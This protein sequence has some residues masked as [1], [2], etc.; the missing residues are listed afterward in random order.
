MNALVT[1]KKVIGPALVLA[2]LTGCSGGSGEDVQQNP[3]PPADGGE[4]GIVYNGPSPSTDDVQNFRLNLWDNIAR[5]DRCG[6][7]HVVGGQQPTFARADDINLAYSDANPLVD[8]AAPELSR[9]VTKVAE[10]HNCWR[11]EASVCATTMAGYIRDWATASGTESNQI[12][13][14]APVE[15]E[16]GTSKS[17]PSDGGNFATTVYPL[18]S[19][20]CANCH[21]EESATQQQPFI[22]SS[23][24]DV[25]YQAARNKIDL[26]DPGNSRLVLRLRSEFHNCWDNCTAN[27]QAMEDAIQAFSD[28][29]PLTEVDP[30]LRVSRALGLPD[31]IVAS[32]GGRVES[33]AIALYEFKTGSGSTAF[34]TSGVDPALDLNITGNVEWVGSWGIRINDGKAQGPTSASSKLHQL[35]T[36]TGEFSIEA[37]VVPDNVSQDGPARIVTYSGGSDVRNFTLGQTLYDY[38]FLARSSESDANGMPMLSTPSN[39]E[40]LQATLQHVVVN[41]DPIDGRSIYVNGELIAENTD[42]PGNLNDWDETFA[43]AVGNEADNQQ[44]WM[45]TM[46][47]LA[48]H[49]RVLSADEITTNFDAGVGEK[50]F[51]MFGV[52][53]YIDMP[54]AYIVFEVQQFDNYAYLFDKPFFIS[55]DRDAQVPDGLVIQ[56]LRIGLNGQEVAIGQSYANLNMPITADIYDAS[57]GVPLS[58]LGAIIPLDRGPDDDQFFLSFDRIGGVEYVR[59]LEDT[60]DA[61]DP[62]PA[63]EQSDIGVR[64]FGEVNATLSSITGVPETNPIVADIYNNVRQQLPT[65]EDIDGFL[66]SHQSGV[67]QLSVAYCTALTDSVALRSN[68]FPDFDFTVSYAEAFT[69]GTDRRD[70][71]ILPL[72]DGLLANDI[73][74]GASVVSLET[75]PLPVDMESELSALIDRMVP[76]PEVPNPSDPSHTVAAVI[77]TCAS[78]LGSAVMLVQ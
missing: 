10:G 26:D 73:T 30:N 48:I 65:V 63:G 13:L 52:S 6:G 54:Q 62:V 9:L 16:V 12:I 42:Q 37:W 33:N 46:R 4:T 58:D 74:I 56:G 21:S 2:V 11:P 23:D 75:Q 39:L 22:G 76:A 41:Y 67:M 40:I 3:P 8:L 5:A 61:P 45:G 51:L 72:M 71:I 43:L 64:T 29:I 53:H 14:T 66:A 18:T 32:S 34:D 20:Y 68:L 47:L 25:A 36:S 49:N 44:L 28:N 27:A 55:L 57:V 15:R 38:N 59:P 78:A 50:F 1:I 17:F 70:L 60:P 35:I 77:A 69:G 19:T 24:V 7:C 31:G